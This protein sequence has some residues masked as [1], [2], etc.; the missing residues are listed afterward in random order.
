[1]SLEWFLRE[2]G[3]ALPGVRLVGYPEIHTPPQVGGNRDNGTP[4]LAH[5]DPD[6]APKGEPKVQGCIFEIFIRWWQGSS[7]ATTVQNSAPDIPARRPYREGRGGAAQPESP[8]RRLWPRAG[9]AP[10]DRKEA[11]GKAPP[12]AALLRWR[13][14]IC[15]GGCLYDA[16]DDGD[17]G[18]IYKPI[19]ISRP[20]S[21]LSW[22]F[23]GFLEVGPGECKSAD[24]IKLFHLGYRGNAV[25]FFLIE[26]FCAFCSL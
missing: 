3:R 12:S 17:I 4:A 21:S 9:H 6:A 14:I 8:E 24:F 18:A 11:R 10:S 7:R 16:C 22:G 1:M 5:A 26:F 23:G 19:K 2:R 13:E 25:I 20:L 15:I